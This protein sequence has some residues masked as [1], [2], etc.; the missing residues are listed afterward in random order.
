MSTDPIIQVA[1][2]RPTIVT[3]VP[4]V[5]TTTTNPQTTGTI[6]SDL[7]LSMMS[8]HDLISYINPSCFDQGTIAHLEMSQFENDKFRYNKFEI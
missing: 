5:A 1:Q 6:P 2:T 4:T 3:N 8:D 7:P